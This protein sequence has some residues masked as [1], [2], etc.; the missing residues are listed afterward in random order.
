MP[1]PQNDEGISLVSYET[2]LASP[3]DFVQ[4]DILTTW[5]LLRAV[6]YSL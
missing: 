3:F 6:H 5:G 1:S 2:R 4:R